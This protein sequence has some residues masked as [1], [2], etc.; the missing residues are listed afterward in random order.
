QRSRMLLPS[1]TV[2]PMLL[3][4]RPRPC[5]RCARL[6]TTRT[7][8][9]SAFIVP[10]AI[11]SEPLQSVA[12]A[13]IATRAMRLARAPTTAA[14][15]SGFT[16]RAVCRGQKTVGIERRAPDDAR[17]YGRRTFLTLVLGGLTSLVWGPA[18]W[19]VLRDALLPVAS[20][21]PPPLAGL[22]RSGWRIYSVTSIPH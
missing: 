14:C 19:N 18:V 9:V 21:L 12:T 1:R 15:C 4:I 22:V 13:P 17:P 5:R 11:R 10:P 20:V 8:T 6:T 2:R 16:T 7:S 3:S